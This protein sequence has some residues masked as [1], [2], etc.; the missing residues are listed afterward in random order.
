MA[1][2]DVF[3]EGPTDPSLESIRRLADVMSRRYGL[4]A[5]ELVT[6]MT[7]GRFRVKGNVERAVADT[8]QKE[9][10]ALGARVTIAP[11]SLQTGSGPV[12]VARPGASA[13]AAA[14]TP[15]PAARTSQPLAT[16]LAAAASEPQVS[17]LG[18]LEHA[19]SFQ[20]GALD[21]SEDEP[22]AKITFVPPTTRSPA[23]GPP[24]LP[25]PRP[26]AKPPADLF[27]PP[28]SAQDR[29]QVEI[30]APAPR[31][32]SPPL[33]RKSAP[34][35]VASPPVII[36][37]GMPRRRIAIGVV[38]AVVLGFIPVHVIASARERSA[39]AAIDARVV[40]AQAKLGQRDAPVTAD[41]LDA[42]RADQLAAKV[43]KRRSIAATSLVIWAVLA[44]GLWFAW[45]KLVPWDRFAR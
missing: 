43:A 36:A 38:L 15:A 40:D 34:I 28:E 25:P 23:D 30:A 22:K 37:P 10:A 3:V 5:N 20:L 9:L 33:Q 11:A 35:A 31:P 1:L 2:F 41:K 42:F 16:G 19:E 27:A 7:K 45:A 21:G 26:S 12:V 17:D 4:P 39:Y 13:L 14:T 29:L 32:V 8:Y 6:R 18:A 44:V 24:S